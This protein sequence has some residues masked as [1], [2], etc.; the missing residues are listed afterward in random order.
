MRRRNREPHGVTVARAVPRGRRANDL[1]GRRR[2]SIDLARA[3][4]LLRHGGRCKG[5]D[6]SEC[7]DCYRVAPFIAMSIVLRIDFC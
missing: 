5:R 3:R 7:G 6:R 1:A 2:G 4:P